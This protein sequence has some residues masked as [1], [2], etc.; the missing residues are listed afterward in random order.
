MYNPKIT[1]M[2]KY[3]SLLLAV[4]GLLCSVSVSAH[5][6]EV[7][8]IYHSLTTSTDMTISDETIDDSKKIVI[9]MRDIGYDGWWNG[10]IRIKENGIETRFAK[11]HYIDEEHANY[12]ETYEFTYDGNEGAI[13]RVD[14]KYPVT[15][16]LDESDAR[17]VWVQWESSYSGQFE[18]H[19]GNYASKTIVVESLF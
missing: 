19:Y 1:I 4:I 3:K 17:H 2:K 14:K 11:V 8:G 13:W 16:T 15:L 10:G 18:L 7:E 9:N 6:F 5:D 12:S